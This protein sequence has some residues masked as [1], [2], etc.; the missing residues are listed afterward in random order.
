MEEQERIDK[1]W[2]EGQDAG[3]RDALIDSLEK[4]MKEMNDNIKTLFSKMDAVGKNLA[5]L[6]VKSGVWGALAG[7]FSSIAIWVA[8]MVKSFM[9]K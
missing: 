9:E 3:R 2:R 8:I 7:V 6:N 4:E 5:A 1:A